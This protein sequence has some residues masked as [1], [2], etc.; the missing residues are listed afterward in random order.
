MEHGRAVTRVNAIVAAIPPDQR[1]NR[2]HGL[3]INRIFLR[4]AAHGI[5]DRLRKGA[6]ALSMIHLF[7][8]ASALDIPPD[9][10][11]RLLAIWLALD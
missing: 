6:C 2:R 4:T 8:A 9:A 5:L 11:L 7:Y 3:C 10:A 1:H